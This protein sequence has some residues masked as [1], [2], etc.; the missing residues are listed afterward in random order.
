MISLTNGRAARNPSAD[1]PDEAKEVI[2]RDMKGGLMYMSQILRKQGTAQTR[3][4]RKAY[5]FP[6]AS[7]YK[8]KTRV[9]SLHL[10]NHRQSSQWHQGDMGPHQVLETAVSLPCS[11]S[12]LLII[13]KDC[14]ICLR[15]VSQTAKQT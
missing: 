1:L 6:S 10:R 13:G 14:F 12:L 2:L 4:I 9:K 5:D 11:F 8:T 7:P 3:R 15:D